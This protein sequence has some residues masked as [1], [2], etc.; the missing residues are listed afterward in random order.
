MFTEKE[1]ER[2]GIPRDEWHRW[3]GHANDLANLQL[4]QGIEN[5]EKSDKEFEA[6]LQS[7]Q[8]TPHEM[9]AYC[10]LHFI[11]D[12]DLSFENFPNFLQA[13]EQII[14]ERLASLLEIEPSPEQ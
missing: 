12:V 3:L 6:W 5:Q 11:P 1:L 14:K 2:R 7:S 10:D 13:R 4:L 8:Q 9:I